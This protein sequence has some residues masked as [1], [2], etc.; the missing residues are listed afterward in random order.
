MNDSAYIQLDGRNV[1]D[2]N[3]I[4]AYTI[5]DGKMPWWD[6]LVN[7]FDL[8]RGFQPGHGAVLM[9]SQ[10]LA[11]IDIT[12]H[13]HTLTFNC[14]SRSVTISDLTIIDT[15]CLNGPPFTSAACYLVH[16]AD[17]RIYG[18]FSDA[19]NASFNVRTPDRLNFFPRTGGTNTWLQIVNYLWAKTPYGA[20]NT[21]NV[22]F[23]TGLPE[24]LSLLST[25]TWDA[26]EKICEITNH[27]LVLKPDGTFHLV[28]GAYNDA[29]HTTKLTTF[30]TSLVRGGNNTTP[31][32]PYIPATFRVYFPSL[33]DQFQYGT[34]NFDPTYM[35]H[36]RTR[37][38]VYRDVTAASLGYTSVYPGTVHVLYGSRSAI[39]GIDGSWANI[40]DCQ[41]DANSLASKYL[42]RYTN[43]AKAKQTYKTACNF[44][45]T[46]TVASVSW[47]DTGAGIRTQF[48]QDQD[49]T[50]ARRGKGS[51]SSQVAASDIDHIPSLS[52][53]SMPYERMMVVELQAA[54]APNTS[55]TGYVQW[56]VGEPPS[57]ND[58]G[59]P[60]TVTVWDIHGNSYRK[61]DR[62]LAHWNQQW[63]QWQIV[64]N[65]TDIVFFQLVEDLEIN[66][67]P[68]MAR[69]LQYNP[70][71][72]IWELTQ[73]YI[74]VYDDYPEDSMFAAQKSAIQ[75]D[76]TDTSVG[77]RGFGILRER[78]PSTGIDAYTIIFCS[79]P[80]HVAQFTITKDY[81]DTSAPDEYLDC[82]YN[83]FYLYGHDYD[84]G[85]DD[86][87]NPIQPKVFFRQGKFPHAVDGSK[88]TAVWNDRLRRYEVIECDQ[89]A[90][91]A[92][93]TLT[94]QLCDGVGLVAVNNLEA[95]TF[96][97]FSKL[98]QTL[99]DGAG[100]VLNLTDHCGEVGDTVLLA[101]D[102]V[103]EEYS[104]WD[105]T[106]KAVEV[107]IA[108]RVINTPATSSTSAS[109][110]TQFQWQEICIEKCNE[111]EW[112]DVDHCCECPPPPPPP[113]PGGCDCMCDN[114]AFT[115]FG[116]SDA[117]FNRAYLMASNNKPDR[118]TDAGVTVNANLICNF[119][120]GY[121][122]LVIKKPGG[123]GEAGYRVAMSSWVCNGANVMSY[124][125]D[126]GGL[127]GWPA[128]ITVSCR[129]NLSISNAVIPNYVGPYALR[130]ALRKS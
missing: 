80:A 77:D 48:Y 92:K 26:L 76:V 110:I 56:A 4:S 106:K 117:D 113:P 122:S 55:G 89:I 120:A 16:L 73:R 22:S 94:G 34:D 65:T 25:R 12:S 3:H 119:P 68:A 64:S 7:R 123:A 116:I 17:K 78:I 115:L 59:L 114:W 74:L 125:Y 37:A 11:D 27:H 5:K 108:V 53:E 96:Y 32:K 69:V 54:I 46:S 36:W 33:D 91:T 35:D 24:N 13:S 111:P 66:Q 67:V 40:G 102:E 50:P 41:A 103:Q 2:P 124:V 38:I 83:A 79:G 130:R 85:D 98:P 19:V 99:E 45:P 63:R 107:P 31:F 43:G 51:S 23:P 44:E 105:V 112:R 75:K 58:T 10:T 128:T 18:R 62:V 72:S 82:K 121:Y 100:N 20:L 1:V 104:I 14:G 118:W 101:W 95:T 9:H 52:R 93:A 126:F 71:T 90:L 6:G 86:Q 88:G 15:E 87:G 42:A 29:A 61:H 39:F 109:C 127:T 84:F 70:D 47:F 21:T 97:P 30:L 8:P 28:A 129:T 49:Y 57:W 60:H 81:R